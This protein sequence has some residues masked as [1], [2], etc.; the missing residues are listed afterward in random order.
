MT[1]GV[2][3]SFTACVCAWQVTNQVTRDNSTGA[4]KSALGRSWSFVPST[5]VLLQGRAAPW[6]EGTA[7]TACLA[8]SPRQVGS[9]YG[10]GVWSSGMQ[11]QPPQGDTLQWESGRCVLLRKAP[12]ASSLSSRVYSVK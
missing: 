11:S 2:S 1:S 4:L 8:K 7:H 5:R 10:K 3:L 6:E 12:D 9:G